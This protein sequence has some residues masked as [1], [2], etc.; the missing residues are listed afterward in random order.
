VEAQPARDRAP[1]PAP[2]NTPSALATVLEARRR[3]EVVC[4]ATTSGSDFAQ[5]IHG[6]GRLIATA[7]RLSEE[8]AIASAL[9]QRDGRYS[10]R[11]SV[12]AA[13]TCH[14][15][16]SALEIDESMLS[17]TVAA[18]LTMNISILR[19]QDKL[20]AQQEPLTPEQHA[21]IQNH[22]EASAALLRER[23]VTDELWLEA[24]LSHHEAIDGSGYKHGR[25]GDQIPVP[26]Q[27]VSLADIYCARISS[28]SYRPALRPNAA[29]RKLFL[30]Q[31]KKV[32]DG[33][34]SQ[35]IKAL[36]VFPPGTPVRLENGEIGVVTQRGESA[37]TPVVCSI[38]GPRGMP[39]ATP[40]RRDTSRPTYGVREVVEWSEV[41]AMPSMH[42]LWGRHGATA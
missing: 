3:L 19:L 25:R 41:G 16:G 4:A 31:G 20:Q 39:L 7:C 8:A 17:S 21:V 15:I 22:P 30:D 40:I 37:S 23:G 29:L 10:I 36:G 18:A 1:A 9:W 11:H 35:F 12:D 5:Q 34:A 13:I 24:V 6:I 32:R 2:E 33:L 38:I 28:R 27:L 42:A 14:V 26:A